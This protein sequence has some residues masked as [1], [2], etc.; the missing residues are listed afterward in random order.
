M[1]TN[2]PSSLLQ[3]TL[4][5]IT[6]LALSQTSVRSEQPLNI[7]NAASLHRASDDTNR[8]IVRPSVKSKYLVIFLHGLRASGSVMATLGT[9]WKETLV[10]TDFVA[11]NAPFRHRSGGHEWFSVDDQLLR[12]DRIEAARRAF[13]ELIVEIVRREGFENDL[14]RVAF[15]GVSQGAIMGLDAIASGRWKV[16]ALV[17][18]AGLL[19]IPPTVQSSGRIPVLL[20]HGGVDR[21]IPPAA[22]VS[23]ARQLKWAG[24]DVTLHVIPGVGHTISSE[25]AR[26]ALR[27]LAN[28]FES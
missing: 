2:R 4:A 17:S 24:F 13:D 26:E 23:A 3:A 6:P 15:V 25:E 11:P 16:G 20:L 28:K 12:P 19:P 21:R 14:N 7:A 18:F 10:S 9:S 27:F 22:S 8:S 5:V 1:R